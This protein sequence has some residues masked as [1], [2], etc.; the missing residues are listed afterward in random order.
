MDWKK[1]IISIIHIKFVNTHT[2]SGW[3]EGS[4]Q[5]LFFNWVLCKQILKKLNKKTVENQLTIK[6]WARLS[7]NYCT[8]FLLSLLRICVSTKCSIGLGSCPRT[9]TRKKK[10][11]LVKYIYKKNKEKN[12]CNKRRILSSASYAKETEHNH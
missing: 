2:R 4:F 12:R 8:H 5:Y 3:V 7:M 10:L 6:C 9:V 1:I 11:L